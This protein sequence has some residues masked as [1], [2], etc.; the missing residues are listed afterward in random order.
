MTDNLGAT[1]LFAVWV[2]D[3][4]HDLDPDVTADEFVYMLN[5]QRMKAGGTDHFKP[6]EVSAIPAPQW[7]TPETMDRLRGW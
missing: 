6:V 5:Q 1:F 4:T 3:A 7:V 2:P